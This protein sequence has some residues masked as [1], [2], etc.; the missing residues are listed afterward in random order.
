MKRMFL[1]GMATAAFAVLAAG[2]TSAGPMLLFDAKTGQVIDSEDPHA[3]WYPAS[4]TKIMT[5]Y[6]AFRAVQAGEVT[7]QSPVRI[8]ARA[9]NEPPSKM[10]YPVGTVLSLDDAIKIIMV[11]S[12]NDVAT[13]IGESVAGSEEA[14]AARMNAKSAR[15]GMTGSHWVNAHGL[16]DDM[17]YTTARD[18]ALL[19]TAM[20][21]DFA[22]H[23][24]YF[25]I[26]GLSSGT[27]V[28]K[29]TMPFW[30]GSRAQT[31]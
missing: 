1:L 8:S 28:I 11:K 21:R 24:S 22:E 6:V 18:L 14:F 29:I 5:A 13:A 15:L 19:A 2:A 17:Q 30:G 7:L 3:R 31:A 23:S 4:L 20:R 25:S 12:A 10:G 9:I 27:Q 16:H 26:D